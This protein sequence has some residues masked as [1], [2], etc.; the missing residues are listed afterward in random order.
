MLLDHPSDGPTAIRTQFGAIF[1][2]LELSRSTWLITSLSPG[3]GEKMSRHSVSASDTAELM[4]LFSELKRKAMARTGQTYP[5]ITIQ[6]A[7]LEG[8][9]LHRVMRQEGI[10][11]HVV[12]PAS[13]ATSRRR[14]RAKTDRLDGEALLR[15]LLAYKR[16][17]PRVCAMVAAPSPE[18]EDRRR[19]SRERR[20]LIAERI[21]HVNRIKGL[22]FA[23]G[24]SDYVP[25]RQNRR[26]R[27]AALRTG[28]GRELPA[29]LKAQISRELD[30][31]ELLLTQIKAV[32]AEQDALLAAAAKF[33]SGTTEPVAMLSALKAMGPNFAIILWS[34]AF[35]RQFSNRRQIAA[36][37]GL[38]ATPWRSGGIEREQGVSKAGN[39]RL[40]TTMIQLAWLWV[41][42]QPKSALTLW[43][44]ANSQRGSKRMIVALARKLLVAL[45]KYVTHGV[46]IEGA[47]MKSAA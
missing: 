11:S 14:R 16:G 40:R 36:Y 47:V 4:K 34:E 43:F 20:T 28:D 13:I 30:R 18:E 46:V 23:Q 41:R 29:H 38:A 19:L 45:W 37:A 35:Y 12:D 42:H 27:L 33:E 21:E 6:E 3:N 1:V 26:I 2:S 17:E 9:W 32:E 24:I 15:A 25:L 31:L 22:L 44:K 10:E 8:F 39:P 5:I 7:G